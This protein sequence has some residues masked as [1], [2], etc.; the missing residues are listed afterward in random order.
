MMFLVIGNR[1]KSR[2]LLKAHPW[3]QAPFPEGPG[4]VPFRE[5]GA[6]GETDPGT[7]APRNAVHCG[8]DPVYGKGEDPHKGQR[9]ADGLPVPGGWQRL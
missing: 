8:T 1:R 6:D 2:L 7:A 5:A 3:P 4:G 9:G